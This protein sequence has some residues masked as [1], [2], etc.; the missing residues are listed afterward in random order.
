LLSDADLER[1]HRELRELLRAEARAENAHRD[2]VAKYPRLAE[3]QA[4][5]GR[6]VE[7]AACAA[8][9]TEHRR[10]IAVLLDSKLVDV[11]QRDR[12]L[13]AFE[14]T[15]GRRRPGLLK[16]ATFP[17]GTWYPPENFGSLGRSLWQDTFL[18]G[19]A[20]IDPTLVPDEL[21]EKVLARIQ[22]DKEHHVSKYSP[23]F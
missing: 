4:E 19:I 22:W 7:E 11:P 21:R 8:D 3:E 14:A 15:V 6:D 23:A 1:E 12:E 10:L 16:P 13:R 5:L 2:S 18:Y 17:V 9:R 20:L